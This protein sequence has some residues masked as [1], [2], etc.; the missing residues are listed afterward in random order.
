MTTTFATETASYLSKFDH[1]IILMLGQSYTS[2]FKEVT[3]WCNEHFGVKFRDWF[4]LSSGKK[5]YILYVK[6]TRWVTM[7]HLKF[8]HLILHSIK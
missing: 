6:D 3:Q 4:M 7:F 1:Q 8:T 5:E 2:N